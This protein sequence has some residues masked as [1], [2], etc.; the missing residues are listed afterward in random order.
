[1]TTRFDTDTA[2]RQGGPGRFEAPLPA[3]VDIARSVL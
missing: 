3:P 1:V 2:V